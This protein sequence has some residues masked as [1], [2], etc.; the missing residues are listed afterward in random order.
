MSYVH[1]A[2][3]ASEGEPDDEA[4]VAYINHALKSEDD[5]PFEQEAELD[6]DL[7]QVC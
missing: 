3:A 4:K 5:L 6:E 1:D 2:Q 7:V